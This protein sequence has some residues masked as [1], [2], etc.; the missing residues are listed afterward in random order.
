M[1]ILNVNIN[2]IKSKYEKY[3]EYINNNKY[4]VV[5]LQE[6][7][8]RRNEKHIISKLEDDT[9]SFAFVNSSHSQHGVITLIRNNILHFKTK[10]VASNEDDF[11]E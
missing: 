3:I 6:V 10:Q 9:K 11:F 2:G 5:N 7:H 4:D 8:L 1:K